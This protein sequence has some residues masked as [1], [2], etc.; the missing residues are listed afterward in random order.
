MRTKALWTL[1]LCVTVPIILILCYGLVERN[2][3]RPKVSSQIE[4][5]DI[6]VK[7]GEVIQVDVLNA[8]GV[9]D[10]AAKFADFLRERKFDVPE[11]GNTSKKL[12][13]SKVYDRVGDPISAK[14]VAYSLGID[15]KQIE[16]R[17]DSTLY[18][19]ATVVIG[20]DFMSLRP[21]QESR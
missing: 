18:L 17:I 20:Q 9:N 11:I 8:C 1:L 6:L 21:M 19:R 7:S 10:I 13:Y 15:P 14:K 5:T 4:Q 16:T 3:L 12:K 2:F